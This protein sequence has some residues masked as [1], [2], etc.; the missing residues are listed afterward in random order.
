MSKDNQATRNRSSSD[1]PTHMAAANPSI[2]NLSREQVAHGE[3]R[4]PRVSMNTGEFVLS[5]PE[6]AIPAGRVGHWFLDDGRGRIE[7]AKAAWWEHV[8][9]SQGVNY[10]A[11]SGAQKMYLMS[12]EKTYYD[13]DEALR[14][15]NYRA[16]LGKTDNE[17][18]GVEGV[19]A[20]TPSGAKN[21]IQVNSDPFA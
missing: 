15:K 9:D 17:S 13:E 19:E 20:Y 4:K 18:L 12:I 7:R 21:K 6:G 11:Q 16:S 2:G 8:T 3:A 14:E 10:T 5:V 1:M